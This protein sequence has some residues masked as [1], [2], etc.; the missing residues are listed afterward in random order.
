M[1][2]FIVREP[3]SLSDHSS[4]MAWLNI[5]TNDN[6]LATTNT[7]DTLTRLPKQFIWESNSPQKFRAA[8]Q[9]RDI[10]RLIHDFLIDSGPDRNINTSLDAVENII[11]TTAKRCLKIK[12]IKK[13]HVRLPANK[14]WFDKDCRLKRHELRKLANLKHRD[15]LNITLREKYHTVLNQYKSLLK[16]KRKEYYHAKISELEKTVDN[17][18]SRS[19][20]NCLKSMDDSVQ[21]R[22]NP[23]ISEK[24]WM[25]HFESLHSN[26]PLNSHQEATRSALHRLENETHPNSLDYLISE[27]EIRKAAKKL[28]NNKSPYSD[29]IKNEMIKSSLNELMPVYLQLFNKAFS[30][31]TMPQNWCDG[32]IA[33]IFKTGSKTDPS[34]YRGICISSCLGKL[35]CSILNQRLLEHVQSHN[36]LLINLKLVF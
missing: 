19:F 8:L 34:N 32:L 23:P 29:R 1:A 28:K 14:K 15:P 11:L 22:N 33:P 13:R 20:W 25:S 12:V 30:S 6:H 3:S 7:N 36:I 18:N 27:L 24:S 17:S 35:F 31:G 21:E 9:S 26:E 10:Q 16:E 2:K 5:G 4:I